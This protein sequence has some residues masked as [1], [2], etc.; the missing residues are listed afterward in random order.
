MGAR[1]RSATS[2]KGP[3]SGREQT[4]AFIRMAPFQ[5]IMT[6]ADLVVV[7]V[8]PA[9]SLQT[10]V[11]R[12]TALGRNLHDI[13]PHSA[14][15]FGP[16]LG[17]CLAGETVRFDRAQVELPDGRTP[18]YQVELSP[19]RDLDG[20]V[21]GLLIASH[22]ITDMVEAL[23][24]SRRS[25]RRL[26]M[27]AELAD[28]HIWELDYVSRTL[29]KVGAEDTFFERPL[30][31]DELVRDIWC[32]VH[33]DDLA[34]AQEAWAQHERTGE[35]YRAEYRVKRSDG[36][37][38]W[39]FSTSD[40][41]TDPQ[42]KPLRLVGALQNITERK[43]TEAALAAAALQ[44][45]AANTAK[46]E[47]LANMSHEIRTPM[48]GV[49]GMNA[50]LLRT[51]LTPEQRKFA[52]AVRTSADCLLN[53]I[54]DILDISK[55]EAGKVELEEIDFCLPTV[56][57][58][59]VELLSPRATEKAL[60]IAAYLDDGARGGFRGDPTRLRQV[61]MNLLTNALKFTETGFVAVEVTSRAGADGGAT[62]RFEVQDT[63]IGLSDEAK[64][65]LF[66]KFQQ[67][68]G[69][70]TRKYGGTGLGLS[71]CRQLVEMMGGQIGVADR[72]GGGSVFW[73]EIDLP[74]AVT[75][76]TTRATGVQDL[77]GLKVLVVDDIEINRSIFVR[78]LEPEGAATTEAADG[79]SALAALVTADAL[80]QPFDVVLLDHMMPGMSGETV[81]AKIRANGA[82]A[83]PRIVLASS[84]GES[85]RAD[86]AA[87]AGFDAVLTK[88][89][90]RQSLVDVLGALRA[91]NPTPQAAIARDAEVREA[92]APPIQQSAPAGP[93]ASAPGTLARGRLLLAEDNEINTLL[94]CTVLEE[95]GYS[96]DCVVNGEEAVAAVQAQPFDLVIM[97]V[98]MPKMDGLQATRAI[99]A[100][101]G[102]VALT[103]ILAMTANAMR[104]DREMC[105]AA[106]MDDFVSK[107]IEAEAFLRTVSRFTAAELWAD[108]ED[109]EP[110]APAP[111]DLPDLEPE[112]LESLGRLMPPAKL[113][114]VVESYLAG[115][116]GRLLRI[117]ALIGELD[118][119]GLAREA[120]DLKGVSGNF[121][122]RRLQA[123][124]EQL[125]RACQA[126][127]EAE[128]PRLIGEIRKSS[129]AAW[130]LVERWMA[131]QGLAEDQRAA[132]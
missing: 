104:S 4:A 67:A 55:L 20:R 63:G 98:Q 106:G 94:A 15:R 82:L 71:I 6:D 24:Q 89:I 125:E 131:L 73:F 115:A 40:L 8:S 69:S 39:T 68:D 124:A 3:A 83:Q 33:P 108:D 109:A 49:I 11:S 117:E 59:V 81:A 54:N 122:A 16:I 60:E 112:K 126:C 58:D 30:T 34:A 91:Q 50:L 130:D 127:D 41:V 113:K 61:L 70:V 46:S 84:I 17:Q 95:A 90:R 45:G 118:F 28:L 105:L 31:Y 1:T 121:G 80:G 129:M 48:N 26:K 74:D 79:P 42:G 35:P 27:A 103:P 75:P 65:K 120:H 132:G 53:L 114:A 96:V 25:E 5:L 18:W 97:D 57:E 47:F 86:R 101:P 43:H 102:P 37:E 78:Q 116:R 62:L 12:E 56:V 7:E 9:W 119:P 23:E 107:P 76:V 21:L 29:F 13:L 87:R 110:A 123:L 2:S 32:S 85:W 88:P 99:R 44:A 52:E 14:E 38:V 93:A 66:N 111:A 51:D 128:A 22:D 36:K 64:G 92:E 10:G 19:W 72:P 100:L 77:N